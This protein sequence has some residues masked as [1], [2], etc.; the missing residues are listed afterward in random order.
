MAKI[1]GIELK[2]V[3]VFNSRNGSGFESNLYIDGKKVGAAYDAGVGGVMNIDFLEKEAQ[4]TFSERVT[5]YFQEKP[6]EMDSEED[7]IEELFQLWEAEKQFK[8]ASKQG[9][10][11][12]VDMDYHKRTTPI[13]EVFSAGYKPS[14][15]V[16]VRSEEVLQRELAEKQPVEY[17][18]FRTLEDFILN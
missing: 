9:L 15:I 6:A 17:T 13:Q 3:K 7:F 5:A 10:V 12:T 16:S 8:K 1:K 14:E 18:V 2:A 11:I 4:Q